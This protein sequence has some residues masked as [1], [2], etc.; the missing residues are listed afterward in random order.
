VIDTRTIDTRTI[1]TVG[2]V[3]RDRLPSLVACLESYLGNCRRH[4]RSPEF[5][6]TDDSPGE[7]AAGRT[8]AALR[9]LAERFSTRLRYAGPKE[10]LRFAAALAAESAVSSE[11]IHFAL[12][13]DPRCDRTTG[14]NR[15]SLFLDTAGSLLLAVDDDTSCRIAEAPERAAALAF[16]SGYDPSEFWFFPDRALAAQ[17]VSFVD[18]DILG[19]HE[20]LLGSDV[21]GLGAPEES[22]GT[23]AMTLNG[24]L[25]DSG[26]ASPRYYLALTGV[27]RDRLVASPQAYRS[28]L[29]S[30]EILRFAPQPTISS[31][32]FCMTTFLGLD[33]RVL[34]PPFFPVQRNSDGIFG[35]MLRKCLDGSRTAF[36][37]W[38]LLHAPEPPRMFTPE[39]LWADAEA[40]RMPDVVMAG[41]LSHDASSGH[42]SAATR[43]SGLGKHLQWLGSLSSTDFEARL[44][45]VQ[46][47]RNFAFITLL[48]SQLRTHAASPDFWADDVRRMIDLMSRAPAAEDY[49]VPRDLRQ[50]RD[51]GTAREL[52]RELIGKFGELL[53]AWPALVAAATR[54]R[55]KGCRLS[56]SV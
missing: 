43:L 51:V 11:I 30:R 42:F 14:A 17:S 40:V 15:N 38:I 37:P 9:I 34:L 26:M 25:G 32:P 23:V 54:V 7:E 16:D 31:G 39:D 47:F 12:F 5:V 44:R 10:K 52:G 8:K 29:E 46:Q 53:E 13:G 50:G 48:Q 22:T 3:T 24:L 33:N 21:A 18:V 36:L 49:L 28:A 27:S 2:I 41:I 56:E 6:V 1:D 20:A 55:A 35:L 19:C 45:T 4:A